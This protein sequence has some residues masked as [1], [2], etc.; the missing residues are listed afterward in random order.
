MDVR[1]EVEDLPCPATM[2]AVHAGVVSADIVANQAAARHYGPTGLVDVDELARLD[3]WIVEHGEDVATTVTIDG[4]LTNVKKA[5][6]MRAG[7]LVAI[8]TVVGEPSTRL[9]S[10]NEIEAGGHAPMPWLTALA[11]V[12]IS[13]TILAA[14]ERTFD[15]VAEALGGD[16]AAVFRFDHASLEVVA[17]T[18]A[19]G[20]PGLAIA[21][22]V[23]ALLGRPGA[24][25]LPLDES[26]NLGEILRIDSGV[27]CSLH[28]GQGPWGIL[29]VDDGQRQDGAGAAASLSTLEAAGSILGM[30]IER[31]TATERLEASNRRLEG[32]AHE[33]AHDLRSPLRRIRSFCE[34]LEMRL[35]QD[36]IDR[37]QVSGYAARIAGGAE[38]LDALLETMLG[39]AT[40][41]EPSSLPSGVVVG[42][43]PEA[44]VERDGW[45]PPE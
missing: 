16:R 38:R 9:D 28:S 10:P 15:F 18:Y 20:V 34:V 30:V 31:E 5:A 27:A 45:L 2:R 3:E 29:V 26:G 24:A 39:Q 37:E 13:P 11:E 40:S 12:A 7:R 36:E 8:L 4:H 35:A 1:L 21:S 33:A 43:S 6:V 23:L 25:G 42:K 22:E 44:F 17:S 41:D 32:Y 19:V 14:I